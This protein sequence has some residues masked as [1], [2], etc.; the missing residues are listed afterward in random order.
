MRMDRPSDVCRAA[1]RAVCNG[2]LQGLRAL[3]NSSE[4][5]IFSESATLNAELV[6]HTPH[7][8]INKYIG[9]I[10]YSLRTF[11]DEWRPDSKRK[12]VVEHYSTSWETT[13]SAELQNVGSPSFHQSSMVSMESTDIRRLTS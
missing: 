5:S 4:V 10:T 2:D 8:L 1:E 9:S 7:F 6:L 13:G 12:A 3:L 11:V